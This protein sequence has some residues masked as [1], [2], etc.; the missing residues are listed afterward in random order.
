MSSAAISAPA[1]TD[2]CGTT[3]VWPVVWVETFVVV[4]GLA[5]EGSGFGAG[6]SSVTVCSR[7]QPLGRAGKSLKWEGTSPPWVFH[8]KTGLVP[9]GSLMRAK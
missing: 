9:F 2:P 8:S 1:A 7:V 5:V 4:T 3:V 6:V